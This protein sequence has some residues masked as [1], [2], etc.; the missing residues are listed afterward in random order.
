MPIFAGQ[1]LGGGAS[2]YGK[3]MGAVGVGAM[4]GA[5][6][7]AMRQQLRGL[8]NIVAYCGHGTG[9]FADSV[10]ASRWYWMSLANS[11]AFRVRDDDAVYVHQ[12]ADSGHG[13]GPA[14]RARDVAVLDDVSGHDCRSVRFSPERS[15]IVLARRSLSRSAAWLASSA[16]QSFP[17]SG[18]PCAARRANWSPRRA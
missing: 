11:G 10:S 17:A 16:A 18:P 13:A 6:V 5:L 8:G 15:R 12:H 4:F 7:L 1:I 3:L 9:H 2:A 14:S